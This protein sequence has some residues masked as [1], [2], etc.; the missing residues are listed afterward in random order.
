M[1]KLIIAALVTLAAA[2]AWTAPSSA[3]PPNHELVVID[4]HFTIP[5]GDLC[6]FPVEF[7]GVGVIRVTTFLDADGDVSTISERP[8]IG[9]TLTNPATGR[10]LTDRDVGLDKTTFH[11]DGTASTL[12]TG[13]HFRAK[14][15][16]SGVVFR[17]IGLQIIHL[18]A[19]GAI[20]DI[21]LRGGRFDDPGLFDPCPLLS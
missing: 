5:A 1:P 7:D 8:N 19:S 15:R 3:A 17:R 18:D 16:G 6:A 13:I 20:S 4:D 21:E 11:P 9:I 10:S 2:V 12:S 14:V